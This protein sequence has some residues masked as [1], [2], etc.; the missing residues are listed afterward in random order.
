MLGS[1]RVM[2]KVKQA[3]F[4]AHSVVGIEGLLALR[5]VEAQ[6]A[7]EFQVFSNA[8][9]CSLAGTALWIC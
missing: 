2:D 8:V 5:I 9:A 7:K 3:V 4:Q 1:V 6:D